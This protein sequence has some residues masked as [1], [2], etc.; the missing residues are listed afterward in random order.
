[1]PLS[2]LFSV[3][4][5]IFGIRNIHKPPSE[6]AGVLLHFPVQN[7]TPQ[8]F[9]QSVSTYLN[10]RAAKYAAQRWRSPEYAWYMGGLNTLN[11]AWH[12]PGKRRA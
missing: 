7:R 12:A 3:P 10:W 8:Q 6:S 2:L 11:Q 4:G 1:M 9:F 5:S